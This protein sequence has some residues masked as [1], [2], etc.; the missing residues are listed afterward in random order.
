MM[1]R[2]CWRILRCQFD[3]MLTGLPS[4]VDALATSF[5]QPHAL[6]VRT[7]CAAYAAIDR[8]LLAGPATMSHQTRQR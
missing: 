7:A 8:R 6:C 1:Q 2:P 5:A 4:A 3:W